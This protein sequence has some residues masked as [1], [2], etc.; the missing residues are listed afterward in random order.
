M[1][2]TPIN[3][4][5]NILL[6]HSLVRKKPSAQSLLC[7]IQPGRRLFEAFARAGSRSDSEENP[8]L[9]PAMLKSL[10]DNPGVDKNNRKVPYLDYQ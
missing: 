7:T 9:R 1:F 10:S 6:L 3:I 5:S 2:G 8:P 4:P